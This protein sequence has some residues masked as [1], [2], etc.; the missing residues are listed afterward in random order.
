[1]EIIIPVIV[2]LIGLAVGGAAGYHYSRNLSAHKLKDAEAQGEEIVTKAE[3]R[4]KELEVQA[5]EFA[6][7]LRNEAEKEIQRKRQEME[8]QEERVQ[9]RQENLDVR[10]EILT[11]K[12]ALSTSAKA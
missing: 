7:R 4:N 6:L 10:L 2:G 9:K 5:K 8:R 12:S 11:G 1:M 3:A